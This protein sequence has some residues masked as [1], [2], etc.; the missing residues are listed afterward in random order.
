[1]YL[2]VPCYDCNHEYMGQTERQFGTR[3]KEHQKAVCHFKSENSALS[4]HA[5]QTKHTIAW[6]DSEIVT[7]KQRNHQSQCLEAWQI[8]INAMNRD[9]GG[10]L[11]EAYL[12]LVNRR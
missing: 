4:E 5:C 11:P 1:M 7:T 2:S 12:H 6:D 8:T 3:S 9:D 10:L